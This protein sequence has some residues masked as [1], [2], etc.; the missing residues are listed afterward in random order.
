M[1]GVDCDAHPAA[2]SVGVLEQ[3][4]ASWTAQEAAVRQGA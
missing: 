2:R 4:R 3:V 1:H